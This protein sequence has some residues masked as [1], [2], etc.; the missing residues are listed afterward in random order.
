MPKNKR[1][2]GVSTSVV[3]LEPLSGSDESALGSKFRVFGYLGQRIWLVALLGL[4]S[5]G[6]LGAGLKYLD[7]DAKREIA[8]NSRER[9]FLSGVNPFM[10][11]PPPE[12][13]PQL[14]KEYVYAGS[15]NL[16][17]IDANA[18]EIPPA[19]LA[20]WRPSNGYWYVKGGPGSTE[21]YYAWGTSGDQVAPGDYDGDGKTDFAIYRNS[22]HY[23]WI[24]K[25][26]DNTYYG[27]LQG[28]DGDKPVP[29]DFDGDG[30][31][32]TAL[33]RPT[34]R[35]WY[36]I[37]S[38]DSSTTS[39]Y[40]GNSG[41]LPAPAD[42]DGDNKT[43][44]A[45]WRPG[46]KTFYPLLSANLATPSFQVG[47]ATSD[48]PVPGDFDGDGIDDFA[49]LNGANWIIRYSAS[50]STSTISWGASGD[51]PV[52]ND[53]DGDGKVDIAG[54]RNGNGYWYIRQSS[55]VG[56]SNELRLVA[57]G[58]AGDIPVPAYYRR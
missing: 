32:D 10:P 6:A 3:G 25:S 51:T 48:T 14:S 19:D 24:I 36:I 45:T 12:P 57:W 31:T 38:S 20:V 15:R 28:A 46:N 40:L 2:R 58:T 27:V 33:F 34:T 42:Y 22:S 54:W 43:D 23:W 26:S 37:K 17:V 52:Q 30:K 41:D 16:A 13:T 53:Y 49:V 44:L 5:L 11:A 8:R 39:T 1:K 47:S 55:Q 29:G 9:S 18:S 56:T 7:E 50:A 35:Y 21:T 4:L